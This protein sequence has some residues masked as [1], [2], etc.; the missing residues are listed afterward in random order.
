M[1]SY[2]ERNNVDDERKDYDHPYEIMSQGAVAHSKPTLSA[3]RQ[4][5][6]IAPCSVPP[7]LTCYLS[8]IARC[9]PVAETWTRSPDGCPS[10]TLSILTGVRAVIRT[11]E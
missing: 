2:R 5:P 4:T 10:L 7:F 3:P 11:H 8:P 6:I 1:Q 9:S